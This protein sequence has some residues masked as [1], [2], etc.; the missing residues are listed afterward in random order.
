MNI[1]D[2]I[3][4]FN[5]GT[6]DFLRFFGDDVKVFFNF[7]ERRGRLDEIDPTI[8]T[9]GDWQNEYLL[10]L[11][12]KDEEKF[13]QYILDMVTDLKIENGKF[14]L[15]LDERGELYRFFCETRNNIDPS[16]IEEILNGEYDFYSNDYRSDDLH[17]DVVDDLNE[18]NIELLKKVMVR[19]LNG[20]QIEP[21]TSL[22]KEIGESQGHED[23][24]L[25]DESNISS[26]IKDDETFN[27]ILGDVLTDLESEL[28]SVYSNSYDSA[29]ESTIYDGIIDELSR[30][31][32]MSE[33]K[34]LTRPSKYNTEKMN[35]YY[36][37]EIRDFETIITDYLENNKRYG[38]SGTIDYHGSILHVVEESVK[39]GAIS[40]LNY[41][42]PDYPDYDAIERMVNENFSDYIL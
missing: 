12:E 3:E 42:S 6:G 9:S 11:Y 26:I 20:I 25:I 16:T 29:Y 14:Y 8:V 40:C 19:E 15:V 2:I 22:L 30:L 18:K 32:V 41:Y 23:Y 33:G 7:L 1:D 4:D 27:Y 34:Y 17:R 38:D 28:S 10:W 31:F 36:E 24:A 35:E 13:Y 37:V 39:D 21:E 5:N